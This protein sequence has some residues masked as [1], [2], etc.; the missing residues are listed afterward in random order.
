MWVKKMVGTN[1]K[2]IRHGKDLTQ[3]DLAD[4]LGVSRQAICMWET[5]K[6]EF[7]VTMLNKLAK[8]LNVSVNEIISGKEEVRS[9]KMKDDSFSGVNNQEKLNVY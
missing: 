6:R 9:H 4:R 7:K 3:K 1:I 8:V 5:G 2:K